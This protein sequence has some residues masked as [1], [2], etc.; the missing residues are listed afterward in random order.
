MLLQII[1]LGWYLSKKPNSVSIYDFLN[2]HV[3]HGN[4]TQ[5]IAYNICLNIGIACNAQNSYAN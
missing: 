2:A 4:V 3:Q 1:T 5:W